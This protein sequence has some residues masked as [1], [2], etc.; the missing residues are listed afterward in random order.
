[1]SEDKSNCPTNRRKG[2]GEVR[3]GRCYRQHA[4]PTKFKQEPRRRKAMVKTPPAC[5]CGAEL[6]PSSGRGRSPQ[7]C[8]V[9]VATR[10]AEH[11]RRWRAEHPKPTRTGRLCA[12][13]GAPLPP[14][15]APGG[16]RKLCDTCRRPRG[17][18]AAR[19]ALRSEPARPGE[20][21]WE[22]YPGAVSPRQT[23][24]WAVAALLAE[25]ERDNP[26]W[27]TPKSWR[28]WLHEYWPPPS[29]VG[30]PTPEAEVVHSALLDW[31]DR[32]P[33]APQSLRIAR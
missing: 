5:R 2:G 13:C 10:N 15:T 25:Y 20:P 29:L 8:R 22:G 24:P 14:Q 3:A 1:M 21:S 31:I 4:R 16:P 17:I 27:H 26:G 12:K 9:C 32:Q 11:Q 19:Q 33:G 23:S 28:D 6:P 7:F 30:L 18:R